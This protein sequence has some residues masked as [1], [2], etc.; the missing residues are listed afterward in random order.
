MGRNLTISGC[1]RDVTQGKNRAF[2]IND[3]RNNEIQSP[4]MMTT[5][6]A[7]KPLALHHDDILTNSG[8]WKGGSIG[9]NGVEK[10]ALPSNLKLND[11]ESAKW[12]TIHQVIIIS[13][14][15]AASETLYIEVKTFI[16]RASGGETFK[17]LIMSDIITDIS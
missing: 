14:F 5:K 17:V 7:P 8:A 1:A 3:G 10:V 15:L 9:V 4:I 11:A 13:I 2:D 16:Y 12:T 6:R